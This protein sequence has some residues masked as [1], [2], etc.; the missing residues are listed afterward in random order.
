M[1]KLSLF[2][3]GLLFSMSVKAQEFELLLLAND[4]ASLLMKNYMTPV[5][6]GMQ[7]GM[8]NGWYHTAKTHKKLG[9]DITILANAAM[10]PTSSQ[11]FEFNS[12]DYKYLSSSSSTINTIMGGENNSTIDIR[13]PEAGNY[14][15][16][17]FTMP[18][19]I[20][21]DVPLSAVPSPMIQASL[22]VF[23]GTD[24]SVRYLPE[25]K[26]DD[27]EGNLI[28]LG[29]KHDI[30]QYLGPLDKL[31]LNI[32][33]F[34][35]FTKMDATYLIGDINGLQGSNQE[36][37]FELTTYTA[38]AI[39]SLDFPVITLYGGIGYEKGTSTL[40]LNGTY[41]LDYTIEG[42]NTTITESVTDPINMDFDTDGI[43]AK[44]GARL[45]IGFFKIFGDYSIKNY[46]TAT[47][48][49]AFS[50]R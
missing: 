11:S 47:A 46:N 23:K 5:M 13:I 24:L 2:L 15:I 26:T 3:L 49:I 10:V 39:A 40:K 22:G 31:P 21:D 25:I 8:N 43:S 16:A 41:E 30:M 6:E 4:D 33:V 38:Q 14:K 17:S 50:F 7:S 29:V 19:G 42:T 35:G 44:I 37:T 48:G 12:A 27:V 1:R 18:D 32:A 34:G 20:K 28:G 45:N 9:F 36:A